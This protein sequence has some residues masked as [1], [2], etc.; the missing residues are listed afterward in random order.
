MNLSRAI[1]RSLDAPR[2]RSERV[3][4]TSEDARDL[5]SEGSERTDR[6][7]IPSRPFGFCTSGTTAKERGFGAETGVSAFGVRTVTVRPSLPSRV[8]TAHEETMGRAAGR[9]IGFTKL[10][11]DTTE[12]MRSRT[13]PLRLSSLSRSSAGRSW[14]SRRRRHRRRRRTSAVRHRLRRLSIRYPRR[15]LPRL[16]SL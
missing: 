9:G 6:V 8:F 1:H 11:G 15:S 16:W 7:Q 13:Q 14:L 2:A 10:N 12:F 3:L 5:N 4:R